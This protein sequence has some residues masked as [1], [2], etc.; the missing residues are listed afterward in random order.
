MI[1]AAL[2]RCERLGLPL[3]EWLYADNTA[4]SGAMLMNMVPSLKGVR[5]DIAHLLRRYS[6][7]LTKNHESA[8]SFCGDMS[9]A[10]FTVDEGD[11]RAL[12]AARGVTYED[13]RKV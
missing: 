4:S 7:T 9:R 2:K 11:M 12:A 1:E 13:I 5:E 6:K 3:P 8:L 10:V